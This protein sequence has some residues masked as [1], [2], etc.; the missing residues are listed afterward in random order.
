MFT[1]KYD[2]SSGGKQRIF[3]FST[4]L[5]VRNDEE[6]REKITYV[7]LKEIITAIG[8][9]KTVFKFRIER[10]STMGDACP[11]KIAR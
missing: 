5:E 2:Y 11:A 4:L 9:V 8:T 6:E 10:C 1:R 3:S 7:H